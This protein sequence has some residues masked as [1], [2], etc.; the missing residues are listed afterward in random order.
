MWIVEYWSKD[1]NGN[2]LFN[3]KM[4][5]SKNEASSFYTNVIA[6]DED[7]AALPFYEED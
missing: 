4:F 6:E 5:H 7:C 3:A 1:L 2:D